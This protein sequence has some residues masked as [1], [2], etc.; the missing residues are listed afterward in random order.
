MSRDVSLDAPVRDA[1]GLAPGDLL[2][3]GEPTAEEQVA[4]DELQQKAEWAIARF[5]ENI[6]ERDQVLLSERILSDAPITLQAIG[7]RFGTSREA[8]RQAEVRLMKQLK[9]FLK[10]EMSP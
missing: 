6:S 2:P 8:A 10:T 3:S 1:E 4:R 5:R 7:D 9:D